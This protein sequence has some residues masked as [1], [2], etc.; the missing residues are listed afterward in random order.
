M[1]VPL[2]PPVGFPPSFGS[3][4]LPSTGDAESTS[5]SVIK[6]VPVLA[7]PVPRPSSESRPIIV[8]GIAVQQHAGA[9]VQE[10]EHAPPAEGGPQAEH[11]PHRHSS[12]GLHPLPAARPS[13]EEFL[14]LDLFPSF[15]LST[16]PP[17]GTNGNFREDHTDLL[18]QDNVLL[19]APRGL[20]SR[21]T[22]SAVA[23][24]L[25]LHAQ[26]H[27]TGEREVQVD[28]HQDQD[29]LVRTMSGVLSVFED[30]NAAGVLLEGGG[31]R[32]EDFNIQE[33]NNHIPGKSKSKPSLSSKDSVVISSSSTNYSYTGR[34]G[35]TPAHEDTS[36]KT[37]NQDREQLVVRLHK[38]ETRI[39]EMDRQFEFE[40][41]REVE[42][43]QRETVDPATSRLQE[44]I[45]TLEAVNR[46]QEEEYL[47]QTQE[48][49]TRLHSQQVQEQPEDEEKQT[50]GRA[51][52][53]TGGASI[54]TLVSTSQQQAVADAVDASLLAG[55]GT[56]QHQHTALG[57]SAS[58][59]ATSSMNHIRTTGSLAI[60][61]SSSSS[62]PVGGP[63]RRSS[64]SSC[65]QEQRFIDARR[66]RRMASWRNRLTMRCTFL[67]WKTYASKCL[68]N[69]SLARSAVQYCLQLMQEKAET[70][71]RTIAAGGTTSGRGAGPPLVYDDVELDH[72]NPASSS[73]QH[74]AT[75]PRATSAAALSLLRTSLDASIAGCGSAC[76]TPGGTRVGTRRRRSTSGGH[77]L[78][79]M[80]NVHL[81]DR[82]NTRR[83][84]SRRMSAGGASSLLDEEGASLLDLEGLP[85]RI[86]DSS[87]STSALVC[88]SRP[89]LVANSA[90]VLAFYY[91][92]LRMRTFSTWKTAKYLADAERARE[93]FRLDL[94]R[95][96]DTSGAE[97]QNCKRLLRQQARKSAATF[98]NV[99]D[100]MTLKSMV[101]G[102][103]K[104]ALRGRATCER[105]VAIECCREKAF[106]SLW[107]RRVLRAKRHSFGGWKQVVALQRYLNSLQKT[108]HTVLRSAI[109]G[110]RKHVRHSKTT[111]RVLDKQLEEAS[112]K[113]AT[114]TAELFFER[115]EG[116]VREKSINSTIV[117]Q[118]RFNDMAHYQ[119]D[120]T[121][122]DLGI[123][124]AKLEAYSELVMR[125]RVREA[126]L[127]ERTMSLCFS[128]WRN[129]AQTSLCAAMARGK[130]HAT[131]I[132]KKAERARDFV[133]ERSMKYEDGQ[134]RFFIFTS[135]S[136]AVAQGKRRRLCG[137]GKLAKFWRT[138]VEQADQRDTLLGLCLDG[139]RSMISSQPESTTRVADLVYVQRLR[140]L[141]AS[142]D[143]SQSSKMRTRLAFRA[144]TG[145]LRWAKVLLSDLPMKIGRSASSSTSTISVAFSAWTEVV[146]RS[147]QHESIA[148]ILEKKQ[149]AQ[150]SRDL[151]RAWRE[152]AVEA[153]KSREVSSRLGIAS[154]VVVGTSDVLHQLQSAA[155]PAS[156]SSSTL[157]EHFRHRDRRLC[158]RYITVREAFQG[159]QLCA[160]AFRSWADFVQESVRTRR[161]DAEDRRLVDAFLFAKK[162][163]RRPFL[164]LL[165][166]D[167]HYANA[168]L[169]FNAWKTEA[170]LSRT[171]GGRNII[172][173]SAV[174]PDEERD[175]E[176][177]LMLAS[178][179]RRR[180]SSVSSLPDGAGPGFEQQ[181]RKSRPAPAASS[182]LSIT[183]P[184]RV[185]ISPLRKNMQE[186]F[187][188]TTAGSSSSGGS[189][190]GGTTTADVEQ[191]GAALLALQREEHSLDARRRT[192][193]HTIQLV[194]SISENF[195]SSSKQT[196][197]KLTALNI[198]R[199]W[200][201][202]AASSRARKGFAQEIN[203]LRSVTL[204]LLGDTLSRRSLD[205][206]KK[207]AFEA[208]RLNTKANG[209]IRASSNA[210]ERQQS[211]Y[212]SSTERTTTATTPRGS[213][214]FMKRPRSSTSVPPA[215]MSRRG[216][217]TFN[218]TAHDPGDRTPSTS[219]STIE[220][221]APAPSSS[222]EAAQHRQTAWPA[223]GHD[224]GGSSTSSAPSQFQKKI[225]TSSSKIPR[226]PQFQQ[227]PAASS[228]NGNHVQHNHDLW[229]KPGYVSGGASGSSSC[230]STSASCGRGYEDEEQD[231]DSAVTAWIEADDS[232]C[233]AGRTPS[234]PPPSALTRTTS[235][236]LHTVVGG[237]F[238]GGSSSSSSKIIPAKNNTRTEAAGH[239]D[240]P[241]ASTSLILERD[242]RPVSCTSRTTRNPTIATTSSASRA[243]SVVSY[244]G[245]ARTTRAATT[246]A[247]SSRGATTSTTPASTST[248]RARIK[249]PVP[250]FAH[251]APSPGGGANQNSSGGALTP[252]SPQTAQLHTSSPS[253]NLKMLPT[254][255]RGTSSSKSLQHSP[256]LTPGAGATCSGNDRSSTRSPSGLAASNI[257]PPPAFRTAFDPELRA[258][259]D[260]DRSVGR[261][262]R[263][264]GAKVV[265]TSRSCSRRVVEQDVSNLS[266]LN[267]GL[268]VDEK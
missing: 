224:L 79:Q 123:A 13:G 85:S 61:G 74:A 135:W 171:G 100:F 68:S 64:S 142:V 35:A 93:G 194:D 213:F 20:S 191:D 204:D 151:C 94:R 82:R 40:V 56:T 18:D 72:L 153:S 231:H 179:S 207:A 185:N 90:L 145:A 197:A 47:R 150:W 167:M 138:Y 54:A 36:T 106:V 46:E 124:N 115:L 2:V 208:L 120:A 217:S 268:V 102:W 119:L 192:E 223:F 122:M 58:S 239:D 9:P 77:Q 103:C 84:S 233:S 250:V 44:I 201:H 131:D 220:G 166:D 180:R 229:M 183:A 196:T 193:H 267:V 42:K 234:N 245:S 261:R 264:G 75:R 16:P 92:S 49:L 215:A 156:S 172:K 117:E 59:S 27:T 32:Q 212:S 1:V 10:H 41:A 53:S 6:M 108:N 254:T 109:R 158:K 262:D 86:N 110:W 144:W 34:R 174:V 121:R 164:K 228:K 89:L 200:R 160:V 225:E 80:Q 205:R 184:T 161:A 28:Q 14:Q 248:R 15:P 129:Q 263:S 107:R 78:Q 146:S 97:L 26:V 113:S 152:V 253:I 258:V 112:A 4:Y 157:L 128:N 43:Y 178:P 99:R 137:A 67:H 216:T 163:A 126:E 211:R 5:S 243:A 218:T 230:C 23:E 83:T 116:L 70:G 246:T 226:P 195:L 33:S 176:S 259:L 60:L 260:R 37:A 154:E 134:R 3:H 133:L 169:V 209:D 71:T 244:P 237:S 165:H 118:E 69:G 173:S 241:A 24:E 136:T 265:D 240:P 255:T 206:T 186:I 114:S 219:K 147:R 104:L 177:L 111:L 210:G 95:H 238:A 141:Q 188:A 45:Q 63:T 52:L 139:W 155:A 221:P 170:M 236:V 175:R 162:V 12:S 29:D 17:L 214:S 266:A 96:E 57:A 232:S 203:G 189:S 19:A 148:E 50:Q 38:A 81:F 198:L 105:E 247:A 91:D 132:A 159:R 235:G 101:F 62:R 182:L 66:N 202:L 181:K 22:T 31:P 187:F 242:E 88:L 65:Y 55:R 8:G 249:P 257:K 87:S 25:Q 98:V 222:T 251:P 30:E 227:R 190:A 140:G 149:V 168:R 7:A 143:R 256:T 252:A 11:A 21:L 51:R 48:L 76:S 199:G 127:E 125:T 73:A 130:E 39:R